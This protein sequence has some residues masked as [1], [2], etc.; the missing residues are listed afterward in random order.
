MP[1]EIRHKIEKIIK[2]EVCRDKG[3]AD[4]LLEAKSV[5]I[6]RIGTRAIGIFESVESYWINF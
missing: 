3:V 1:P 5:Q 2:T 4:T 6:S